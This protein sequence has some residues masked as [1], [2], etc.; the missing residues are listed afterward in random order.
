VFLYV[1]GTNSTAQGSITPGTGIQGSANRVT[2]GSRQSGATTAYDLQFLG[3]MEEVAIYNHALSPA[4]VQNHYSAATNR[5]PV[6][7]VNPFTLASV[8]AGQAYSASIVTNASDP[9]GD[10]LTFAKVTGPSWLILE[11]NGSVFGTALSS[12][13][14]LNSFLVSVRDPGGLSNIANMSLTVLPAPPINVAVS[15]QD[16]NLLLNWSGGISPY[17]VEVTTNLAAP[18]W[19]S[20]GAPVSTGPLTLYPT[21]DAA[22]YRI[23][24]Q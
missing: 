12:N 23:L 10:T 2:I 4:Q 17:Q 21:N 3:L 11:S 15:L 1:D 13:V 9:N 8:I 7:L 5:P 24:G 19:Q 22:F 14:G 6:F 18:D 16:T 20:L